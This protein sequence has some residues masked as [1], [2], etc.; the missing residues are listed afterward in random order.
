MIPIGERIIR[1]PVAFP[2]PGRF[3]RPLLAPTFVARMWSPHQPGARQNT[4]LG[5]GAINPSR[6]D[7]RAENALEIASLDLHYSVPGLVM[8][9]SARAIGRLGGRATPRKQRAWRGNGK[10]GGRPRKT[11]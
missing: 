11:G 9:M 2:S 8:A 4:H 1:H 7:S 6:L 3:R 10:K 5:A